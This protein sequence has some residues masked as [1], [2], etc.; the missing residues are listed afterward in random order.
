MK[1]IWYQSF[2]NSDTHPCY[3]SRLQ[4]KLNEYSLSLNIRFF[5][6]GLN[7]P[8]ISLHP[9]SEFMCSIEVIKNGI[10]AEEKGFDAYV[11]GHFQEPGLNELKSTINIPVIGLGEAS[12][13]YS[14]QLGQKIGLIT[15][16]PIFVPY[17]EKQILNYGL[18]KRIISV[19]S[20]N[21]DPADYEKAFTDDNI[22]EKILDEFSELIHQMSDDGI[23][24]VIPSGGLP[25]LL[26]SSIKNFKI[27]DTVLVNGIAVVVNTTY[28]NLNI[29]DITGSFI[30]RRGMYKKADDGIIDEFVHNY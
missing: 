22:L 23:E 26:F 20:V 19:K 12:M 9:L 3:I 14:C 5:V 24:V 7:I 29:K 1:K 17:H 28:S 30:S 13:L 18:E 16:N 8:D 10:T 21:T 4:D 27:N 11:I 25:M 15:I 6:F 2:V